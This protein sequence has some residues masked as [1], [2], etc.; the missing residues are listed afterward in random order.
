MCLSSV[1]IQLSGL[2]KKVKAWSKR[3][4]HTNTSLCIRSAAVFASKAP[5]PGLELWPQSLWTGN[6]WGNRLG[7]SI[8][9]ASAKLRARLKTMPVWVYSECISEAVCFVDALQENTAFVIPCNPFS[10]N[11]SALSS[12]TPHSCWVPPVAGRP[13]CPAWRESEALAGA[14]SSLSC[15][16][17]HYVLARVLT[18]HWGVLAEQRRRSMDMKSKWFVYMQF[19][20]FFSEWIVQVCVC[21]GSWWT[22]ENTLKRL[23]PSTYLYLYQDTRPP[24][25]K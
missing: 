14:N 4:S 17:R 1:S 15:P 9:H 2:E 22:A 8:D 21:A 12:Q 23:I 5:R 3:R 24:P 16:D 10:L 7:V 18:Q 25:F 19:W 6:R 13:G 11:V 20:A